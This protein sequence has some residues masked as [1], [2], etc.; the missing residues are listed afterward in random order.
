SRGTW[1]VGLD[2]S[3]PPFEM[4]DANGQI[5]GFDVA[6]AQELAALWGLEVEFVSI[7]FDSLLDAVRTGQVDSVVS[8]YPYDPRLTRDVRFSTPYFEAGIRLAI[9]D[10]SP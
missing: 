4:L 10:D 5:I 2:P 8:A 6:L 7:G 3:F 1:R 9:R